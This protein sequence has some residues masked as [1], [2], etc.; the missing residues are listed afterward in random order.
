MLRHTKQDQDNLGGSVKHVLDSLVTLGHLVD[1]GPK[2][3][4]LTVTEIVERN[5]ARR[6][7][8][9]EIDDV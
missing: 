5:K 1:D 9:V 3:I 7:T 6:G 2:W 4:D 8:Y